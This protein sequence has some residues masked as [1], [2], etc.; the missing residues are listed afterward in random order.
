M[1][2]QIWKDASVPGIEAFKVQ[3]LGNNPVFAQS[4]DPYLYEYKIVKTKVDKSHL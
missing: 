1:K 3:S 4:R 2:V